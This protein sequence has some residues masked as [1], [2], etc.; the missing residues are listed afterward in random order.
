MA[1][2]SPTLWRAWL[3]RWNEIVGLSSI[4][5][6]GRLVSPL[7]PTCVAT[8][9]R[10]WDGQEISH[11]LASVATPVERNCRTLFNQ[12]YRPFGFSIAPNMRSH[13]RQTVGWPGNL[14]RSGERG[15]PGGTKL[16]DSLQSEVQAVW[17]LHCA[18]HA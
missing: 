11:A 17:F 10:P 1:R 16:S 13:G 2:K 9:A 4:R 3:P 6:T 8:V 14:P 18:Q 7:R 15:Y 5:G 12:R